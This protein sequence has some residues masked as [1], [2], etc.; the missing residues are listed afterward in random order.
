[1]TRL[2]DRD[3]EIFQKLSLTKWLSTTQIL[4]WFFPGKSKNAV[5]KRLRKLVK[6]HYLYCTRR[7]STEDYYF[8]LT[9]KGINMLKELADFSLEEMSIPKRL[10][11]N[12]EHFSAINDLRY[13]FEKGT[14]KIK[15]KIFFFIPEDDLKKLNLSLPVIPDALVRIKVFDR[16]LSLALEYDGG[17]ENPG[18]FAKNKVKGY[19]KA[20]DLF[21]ELKDL[22]I[23]VFAKDIRRVISL[24]RQTIKYLPSKA[25]F[26][27]SPLENLDDIFSSIFLDP[28]DFF[29]KAKFGNKIKI[30]EKPMKGKEIPS[31]SLLN[32]PL[33]STSPLERRDYFL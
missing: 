15:G 4:N 31:Y 11:Q 20:I 12:L 8:R 23:L 6:A 33:L 32:L 3:L 22:R 17:T 9:S 16:Y 28:F 25:R 27:F 18:F 13:Y 29:E 19:L 24:M 1:M 14:E 5:N 2:T 10:P 30:V 26:L 7:S 21:S